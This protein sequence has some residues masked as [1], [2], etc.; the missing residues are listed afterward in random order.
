MD[1]LTEEPV[2]HPNEGAPTKVTVD[3]ATPFHPTVF[4]LEK[5]ES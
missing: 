4:L 3:L 2:E 5:L 1:K